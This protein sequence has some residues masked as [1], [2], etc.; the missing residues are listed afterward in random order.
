MSIDSTLPNEPVEVDEPLIS[1]D[2]SKSPVI[3]PLPVCVPSH[4]AVTPVIPVPSPLK[5]DAVT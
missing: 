5:Y 3:T 1:P 2:T 4:S